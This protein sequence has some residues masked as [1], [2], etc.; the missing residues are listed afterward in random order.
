MTAK[1]LMI[2]GTSSGSGKTTIVTALCR[3]FADRGYKV[4][5]FKSQNMSSKIYRIESSLE[6]IS[7]AQAVQAFASRKNPDVRM[8]PVLLEPHGNYV[9]DVIIEGHS[10]GLMH[11]KDYYQKFVLQY[12]F[13]IIL[14]SLDSLRKENDIVIMEGAGSP[15]EINIQPYDVANMVLAKEVN[16]PVIIIADIERG[17][18]FASIV[19]TMLLLK[20]PDRELVKG[21]M[22]NKFLGDELLLETAMSTVK[23]MTNKEFFGVVSKVK[24]NLPKEDS[25]DSMDSNDKNATLDTTLDEQIQ[26]LVREIKPMI[27]IRKISKD[28][29]ELEN[30]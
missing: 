28:L 21:F 25:L 10:H 26:D 29:L 12:A 18:C 22:I 27:D 14:N 1:I 11:A 2:Q 7:M 23:L 4:A 3:I 24:L 5:P 15:A 8:N 6:R 16:A 20:P 13:P 9:S 19:G 30:D 17:G